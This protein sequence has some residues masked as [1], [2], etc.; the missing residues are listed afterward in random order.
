MDGLPEPARNT[1]AK[2]TTARKHMKLRVHILTISAK[3]GSRMLLYWLLRLHWGADCRSIAK[4]ILT[5]SSYIYKDTPAVKGT[6]RI[7][8]AAASDPRR[9]PRRRRQRHS[10]IVGQWVIIVST[11]YYLSDERANRH[12]C[13][14][15]ETELV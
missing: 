13:D 1:H 3:T 11:I 5:E 2:N 15:T 4:S 6:P 12:R 9:H 8:N 7:P 10:C 14:V